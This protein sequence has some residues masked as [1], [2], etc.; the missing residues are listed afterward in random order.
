MS[1]PLVSVIMTVFNCEKFIKDALHS[2]IYQT[3]KDFEVIVYNDSSTDKTKDIIYEFFGEFKHGCLRIDGLHRLGCPQGRNAAIACAR[4]KYIAI[5]DAD[6]LSLPSRLEEQVNFLEKK[7]ENMFCVGAWAEEIDAAG[8]SI[9]Q[10]IY[11]PEKHNEIVN[12]MKRNLNPINPMIDSST[13]F[14]KKEFILLDGYHGDKWDLVP[15]FYL[16]ARAV[17]EDYEFANIPKILTCYRRHNQSVTQIHHSEAIRQHVDL[18][19]N[20]IRKMIKGF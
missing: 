1:G 7:S 2:L 5:Q 9:G 15:D 17:V 11:P 16:W 12:A 6:D 19:K 13:M 3:F 14:R 20:Y 8:K 4:G 10:M 18:C